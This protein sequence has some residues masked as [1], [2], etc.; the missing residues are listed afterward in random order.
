[1]GTQPPASPECLDEATEAFSRH[2]DGLFAVAYSLLGSVADA[3]DVLQETWLSWISADRAR[4]LDP[5]AYLV[6]ITVNEALAQLRRVRRRRENYVGPWLP[7]P[8]LTQAD[9]VDGALRSES[10]SLAMLVVLETLTPLERAVFVLHEAFGYHHTEVAGVLGRSPGAVRQLAHR[11][12]EKIQDRRI[13]Y[14]P[15]P[16]TQRAATERFLAAALGGDLDSLMEVLAPEVAMWSDAG[17]K[18]TAAR[19][20]IHGRD[21]VLR[22]IEAATA[23]LRRGLA[24]RYADVNGGPAAV[25]LDDDAPY[26]VISVDLRPQ[27]DR[28]RGIYSVLNPDKLRRL[29][30]SPA[31][32]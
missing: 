2:R 28:V 4:V 21:K 17:G 22:L 30:I 20:P 3:D 24:I 27:D 18:L 12:R 8:L 14:R 15:E 32:S 10:V 5:R 25:L 31:R 23:R 6:R 7:E 13:R 11:A 29:A 19:N 16:G 1:M 26:A 9:T